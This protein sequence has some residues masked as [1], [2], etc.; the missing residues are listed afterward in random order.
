MP[1][2]KKTRS[3]HRPSLFSVLKTAGVRRSELQM[4]GLALDEFEAIRLAD[5]VGQDHA[6]SLQWMDISRSTF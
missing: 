4:L 1:R 2:P 5:Y 6:E 3:A